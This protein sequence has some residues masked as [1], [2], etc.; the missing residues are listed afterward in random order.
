MKHLHPPKP[1]HILHRI[2]II[3]G[4]LRGIRRMLEEDKYCVDIL[5]QSLAVQKSLRSLDTLLL[6]NHLETCVLSSMK[7][8]TGK[9]YIDELA[10][11][12]QG[13]LQ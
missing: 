5:T 4:Q 6:K 13:I 3:E 7:N 8:K 9:K 2:K 12:Y 1:K 10:R 11:L